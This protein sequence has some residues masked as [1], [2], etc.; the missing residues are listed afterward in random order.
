[1]NGVCQGNRQVRI[2]TMNQPHIF[3]RSTG[4]FGNRAVPFNVLTDQ[5]REATPERVIGTTGAARGNGEIGIRLC[6]RNTDQRGRAQG[7]K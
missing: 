6:R 5:L 2:L 1:M 4:D 7:Q 3:N